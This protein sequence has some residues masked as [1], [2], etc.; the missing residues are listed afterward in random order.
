[1]KR[2]DIPLLG[3]EL[4]IYKKEE[5]EAFGKICEG[6]GSDWYGCSYDQHIWIGEQRGKRIEGIIAHELTHYVDWLLETRLDMKMPTLESASELRAY[7]IQHLY[8]IVLD[9]VTEEK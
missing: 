6:L 4:R 8:P 7:I 3:S 5:R 1:M 2:V 9:Y